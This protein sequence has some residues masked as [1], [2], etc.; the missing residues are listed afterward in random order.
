MLMA[1]D[2]GPTKSGLV[3]L[4]L[5]RARRNAR[6]DEMPRMLESDV[7]EN[8]DLLHMLWSWQHPVIVEAM[9]TY[10][11]SAVG[12][13]TFSTLWWVGRFHQTLLNRGIT[14]LYALRPDVLREL[15]GSSKAKKKAMHDTLRHRY[16]DGT[17]RSVKG[18]KKN[19]GP[20]Y[21]IKSHAW[22]ALALGLAHLMFDLGCSWE[23]L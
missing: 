7:A 21:G 6:P 10:Q 5:R 18:T 13:S 4:E 12:R 1:I 3:V 19:P 11:S 9:A 22:D 8:H 16:G 23:E 17:N 15:T 2:P 20:L 14:P